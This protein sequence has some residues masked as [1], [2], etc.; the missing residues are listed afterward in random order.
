MVVSYNTCERPESVACTGDG[1]FIVTSVNN[2]YIY[3]INVQYYLS[4]KGLESLCTARG[5]AISIT[6]VY[7]AIA[8]KI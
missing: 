7:G 4:T 2:M 8:P 6:F 3:I 5:P 1:H